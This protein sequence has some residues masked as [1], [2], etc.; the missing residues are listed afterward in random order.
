[1]MVTTATS[2]MIG[3][4]DDVEVSVSVGGLGHQELGEIAEILKGFKGPTSSVAG[5]WLEIS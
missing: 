3:G 1:M 5:N 4:V 2:G